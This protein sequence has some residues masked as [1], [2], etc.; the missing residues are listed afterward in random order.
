MLFSFSFIGLDD[1]K[2]Q[3][4]GFL[5]DFLKNKTLGM[6]LS[7]FNGRNW[8]QILDTSDSANFANIIYVVWL[9][10]PLFIYILHTKE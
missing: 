8:A 9:H 1:V 6:L 3:L 2:Q 5:I 10:F 7:V 4:S